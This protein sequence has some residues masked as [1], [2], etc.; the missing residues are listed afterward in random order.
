[1]KTFSKITY[2][3]VVQQFSEDGTCLDQEFVAG[4]Q[5]E[6]EDDQGNVV[7]ADDFD[8]E[9]PLDMVQPTRQEPTRK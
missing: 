6:I 8:F 2:G 7:D 1:M 4:D 5:V 9:F 3:F